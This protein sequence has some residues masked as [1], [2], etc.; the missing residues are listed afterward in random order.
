MGKMAGSGV[1]EGDTEGAIKNEERSESIA[2]KN[3]GGDKRK[4]LKD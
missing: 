3:G 1:G 4:I 2:G